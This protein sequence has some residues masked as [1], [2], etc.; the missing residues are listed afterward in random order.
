[1]SELHKLL[2][3]KDWG[4]RKAGTEVTVDRQRADWLLANG[5]V[6]S[7]REPKKRERK[8]RPKSE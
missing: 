3:D 2:L 1:M 6:L 4:K 7:E 5:F 8:R